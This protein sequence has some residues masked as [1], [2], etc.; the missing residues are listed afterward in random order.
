MVN[1]KLKANTA[2]FPFTHKLQ[3]IPATQA[4]IDKINEVDYSLQWRY[5]A[6]NNWGICPDGSGSLGCGPQE[7]FR[8][9]ADVAIS[10]QKSR[11][12]Y[13]T[14]KPEVPPTLSPTIIPPPVST[15]KTEP[16]RRTTT[17]RPTTTKRPRPLTTTTTRPTPLST[18]TGTLE[19]LL[20]TKP[21][22]PSCHGTNGWQVVN[23]M[24]EWCMRNC[25]HVPPFCP[26]SH[27]LCD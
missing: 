23:G 8:A 9:C 2:Y 17:R 11:S 21:P 14:P 27:C 25:N 3:V 15:T 19:T 20:P 10:A 6:G 26:A 16:P 5:V 13:S 7:E 18:S 1:L 12:W 4:F 22:G 24:N